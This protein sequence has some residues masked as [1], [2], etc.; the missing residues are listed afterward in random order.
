MKAA[1]HE[2][3][4]TKAQDITP[5]TVYLY[6]CPN[7]KAKF[8]SDIA[9]FKHFKDTKHLD[10]IEIR[11]CPSCDREFYSLDELLKHKESEHR[12]VKAPE[13]APE[14]APASMM[15]E[16][17]IEPVSIESLR[18]MGLSSAEIELCKCRKCDRYFHPNS[19]LDHEAQM[20]GIVIK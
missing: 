9:L 8:E 3:L 1:L 19:I 6:L 16:K 7:C 17:T 10:K 20:H 15:P 5:K 14:P 4:N 2:I 13:P 12:Q 18:A 11:Y